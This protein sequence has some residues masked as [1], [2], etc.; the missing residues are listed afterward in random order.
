LLNRVR[1][2]CAPRAYYRLAMT[3]NLRAVAHRIVERMVIEHPA[4]AATIA[5]LVVSEILAV[6]LFGGDEAE[7]AEFV[8]A[9]NIKVDEIALNR[10]AA[11][12]WRLVRAERPARH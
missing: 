5:S 10:G 7:V 4:E 12:S 8:A 2:A 9:V 6:G 1:L 11:T 3:N